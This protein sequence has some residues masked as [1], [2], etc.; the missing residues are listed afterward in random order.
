MFVPSITMKWTESIAIA[1]LLADADENTG[2]T[3]NYKTQEKN[4][5][6]NYHILI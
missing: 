4:Y 6:G 3:G 5:H 1:G 2:K